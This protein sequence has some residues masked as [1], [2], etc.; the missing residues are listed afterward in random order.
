MSVEPA[1]PPVEVAPDPALRE[2][3]AQLRGQA[4]RGVRVF[5]ATYGPAEAAVRRSGAEGSES[6]I[7]AQQAVSRLEAARADTTRALA[8][9]HRISLERADLPTSADDQQ[10]LDAAIAEA[11]GFA[12]GQQARI[13]LLRR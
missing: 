8:E 7:D 4:E 11:E 12:A 9:L 1:R 6:W 10:M 3:V 13:D 5:D 2:R